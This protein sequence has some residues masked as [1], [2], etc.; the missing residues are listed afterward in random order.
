MNYKDLTEPTL[1]L[2]SPGDVGKIRAALLPTIKRFTHRR[3]S[4][5]AWESEVS[6][7]GFDQWRPIQTQIPLPSNP[8]CKVLLCVFAERI[9]ST[10]EN[11]QSYA[12][13]LGPKERLAYGRYRLE[14]NW[15]PGMESTGAFSLT[16][17]VF[18]VLVGL[19]AN[20]N[21]AE[22]DSRRGHPSLAIWFVGDKTILDAINS[23]L[24]VTRANWGNR[25]LFNSPKTL[26]PG[27]FSSWD[28]DYVSQITQL[29]NFGRYLKQRG[30]A[31]NESKLLRHSADAVR[32]CKDLLTHFGYRDPSRHP[33][34]GLKYYDF[35]DRNVFCGRKD[36][37][38][39]ALQAFRQSWETAPGPFYG[40]VGASGA[41]KSSLLRA[42]MLPRLE[43]EG[44]EVAI[45]E[46]T[47]FSSL[48]ENT[49]TNEFAAT[50]LGVVIRKALRTICET[51]I[52]DE[53]K[54]DAVTVVTDD[55][56]ERI[57]RIIDHLADTS[58]RVDWA[59]QKI[60][61]E[62]N[63]RSNGQRKLVIGLDQFEELLDY[64]TITE[65][66]NNS[67]LDLLFKFIVAACSSGQI[68]FIYTCQNNRLKKLEV[69][70]LLAPIIRRKNQ[71]KVQI[72]GEDELRRMIHEMFS[73]V[74][75]DLDVDILVKLCDQVEK[76]EQ[77]I[78][79]SEAKSLK[80]D[81]IRTTLLPLLSLSLLHLY[82][83]CEERRHEL[84]KRKLLLKKDFGKASSE[85]LVTTQEGLE[86]D[87]ET[88]RVELSDIDENELEIKNAI[89]V[90]AD[91]AL[92][93]ARDWPGVIWTSEELDSLLLRLVRI[94]EKSSGHYN[95]LSISIPAKG[96]QKVLVESFIEHRLLIP[97]GHSEVRLVH[98]AVI[99]YWP[100]AKDRIAEKERLM[101]A[102]QQEF[103]R[104]ID[105]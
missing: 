14:L 99:Q 70:P 75:F 9:G 100:V 26:E 83:H 85:E 97:V 23:K 5:Y 95:L 21:H 42:G 38:D 19:A 39:G 51:Q 55:D 11:A 67:Q 30:V 104:L 77:E 40:V 44:Y 101:N 98:E 12:Q 52:F 2:A 61:E 24:D 18:E 34:K 29:R 60:T 92:A 15:Q 57:R 89:S 53:E 58:S 54:E 96:V 6:K 48:N 36:W 25:E 49:T 28:N 69:D 65:S 66:P 1:F 64:R 80:P 31:I 93:R 79:D 102:D 74:N 50:P 68:G 22:K 73:E 7:S 32:K 20:D 90:L 10:M 84:R 3:L 103:R 43:E 8:L 71:H 47:D 41:G 87:D 56:E 4:P 94:K 81:E 35:A 82:Q 16:G 78:R 45:C 72:G 105:N 37:I 86:D 76:L 46:P 33:F 13:Y 17:T 91:K 63:T 27:Q 62:L 59:V 88:T